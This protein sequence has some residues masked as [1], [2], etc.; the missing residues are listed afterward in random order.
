[1]D[2]ERII[3]NYLTLKVQAFDWKSTR[4]RL[5]ICSD[6]DWKSQNDL[7]GNLQNFWKEIC[8]AFQKKY[9]ALDNNNFDFCDQVAAIKLWFDHRSPKHDKTSH[10]LCIQ[11]LHFYVFFLVDINQNVKRA[12]TKDKLNNS[13]SSQPYAHPHTRHFAFGFFFHMCFEQASLE[14]YLSDNEWLN[15]LERQKTA[16]TTRLIRH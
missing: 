2:F 9:L 13:L 12:R 1:M 5:E 7:T 6:L 8:K 10:S 16:S 15:S 4:I 11:R 14:Q 3:C